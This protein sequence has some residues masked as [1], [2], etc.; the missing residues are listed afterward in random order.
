[1]KKKMMSLALA[2]VMCFTL[3]VPAFA[4]SDV[5]NDSVLIYECGDVTI[6]SLE[7]PN[8]DVELSQYESNE[9]VQRD[10]INSNRTG[11]VVREFFKNGTAIGSD[12]LH[13][14]DYIAI[15]ESPV[16][17]PALQRANTLAGTINY[18]ATYNTGYVYYGARCQYNTINVGQTTYTIN[19]NGGAFVDLVSLVVGAISLPSFL[20]SEFVQAL[21]VGL[22]I[23]VA[24][25]AI[26]GQVSDTVACIETV[27]NW[28]WTD[29]TNSSNYEMVSGARYYVNDTKSAVKG[30]NYYDGF[31]PQDWGTSSFAGMV[32]SELFSYLMWNVVS[33]S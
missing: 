9:L 6:Y 7:K 30:K 1:M 13:V 27:Y 22:G 8:G 26:K 14:N 29:T 5:V 31:V 15:S 21:L 23:S 18:R 28:T 19:Q 24:S 33:W 10:T 25:G 12:I 4:A 2:L 32:H 11:V 17:M 20:A 16:Q 3:S